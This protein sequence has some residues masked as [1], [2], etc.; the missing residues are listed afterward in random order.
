MPPYYSV[1]T[2]SIT[3][4]AAHLL[5][6]NDLLLSKGYNISELEREA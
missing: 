4:W 2:A 1:K 3:Y 6:S 5:N